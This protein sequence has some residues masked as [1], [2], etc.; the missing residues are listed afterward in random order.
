MSFFK[1]K[2]DAQVIDL[3]PI[4]VV[5]IRHTGPYDQLDRLFEQ[6]W[7]WIGAKNVPA[8]R[9]I[10][11]YWDNP[12]FTAP[13]ALRSAACVEVPEDF[14]LA[15][16]GGLPLEISEI[17]GGTYVTLRY[18]G[19]YDDLASVWQDLTKSIEKNLKRTISERPAFEV[20]VNDASETEPKDLITELYMPIL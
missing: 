4:R 11:I 3:K 1:K 12:D 16:K 6:L 18:V 7:K 13:S 5:M 15:D 19:P 8:Q 9:T 2:M 10:G 20:Y 14:Q 17:Y